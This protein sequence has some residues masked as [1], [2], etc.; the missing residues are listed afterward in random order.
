M[1][2]NVQKIQFALFPSMFYHNFLQ[3]YCIFI[4]AA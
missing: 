4:Y 1:I 2:V 3:N